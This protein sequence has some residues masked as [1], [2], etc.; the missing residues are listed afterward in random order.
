VTGRAAGRG[1]TL[2]E[3]LVALFIAAVTLAAA[4]RAVVLATDGAAAA[5]ERDLALWLAKNRLAE[6]QSAPLPPPVGR[7]EGRETL[8]G[9][10]LLWREEVSVSPNP[11]FSVVRVAVAG[12]ERP[13]HELA[14]LSGYVV[15]P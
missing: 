7:Q 12:A 6:W 11:R 8:A 13:E 14:R 4:G 1:F 3:V 2:L 9:L 15:R 5:R 10:D